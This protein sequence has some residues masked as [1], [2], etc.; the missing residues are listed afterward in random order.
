MA[1]KNPPINQLSFFLGGHDLEMLTISELL[2]TE[3]IDTRHIHDH[4]LSWGAGVDDYRDGIEASLAAGGLPVLIELAEAEVYEDRAV[5]IDH[6]NKAAGKNAPTSLHQLFNL[7]QLP[8][9]RWTRRFELV[10]ANDR[11]YIP[12]L[13]EVGASRH[14]IAEIR[15]ADRKAQGISSEEEESCRQAANELEKMAGGKLTI[16]H[17]PHNRTSPLCD[18]LEQALGG[19][20]YQNLLVLCPTEISF[21]GDGKIVL[22]LAESFPGSWYGGSLPDRGYWGYALSGQSS[23]QILAF[24]CSQLTNISSDLLPNARC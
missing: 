3:G 7:L 13:L 22:G 17:L 18:R 12:A 20:G 10:A 24:I 8:A 19:P 11:G 15:A 4:G 5:I 21:F 23:E 6:H 16:A 9:F 1:I 2:H 14:E